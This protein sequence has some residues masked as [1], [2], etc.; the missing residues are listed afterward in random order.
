MLLSPAAVPVSAVRD[1][2]LLAVAAHAI[3][4]SAKDNKTETAVSTNETNI[5]DKS[6]S[7]SYFRDHKNL[8]N[9]LPE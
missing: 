1:H 2:L 4:Q 7:L 3:L 6:N 5:K 8:G 9:M